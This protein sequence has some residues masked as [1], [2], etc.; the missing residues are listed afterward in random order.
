MNTAWADVPPTSE[1]DG[2]V[3]GRRPSSRPR[4]LRS[5]CPTAQADDPERGSGTVL[6][7]GL[8]AGLLTLVVALAALGGVLVA[9]HRARA[10]ADL[11]ALA[12]AGAVTGAFA[13]GPGVTGPRPTAEDRARVDGPGTSRATGG[14]AVGRDSGRGVGPAAGVSDPVAEDAAV[15]AREPCS[16]AA[17][18]AERNGARL[19][20]CVIEGAEVVVETEVA[21]PVLTGVL[22]PARGLA[23]AG[24]PRGPS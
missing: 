8:V 3:R 17:A 20:R 9:S 4:P 21:T 6:A 5:T 22:G 14:R 19:T 7:V 24:P 15:G 18:V 2:P 10:A 16:R 13:A 12:G 1:A 23:R 11:S